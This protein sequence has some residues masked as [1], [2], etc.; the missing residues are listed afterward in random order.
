MPPEDRVTKQ[1]SIL[2]SLGE[3]RAYEIVYRSTYGRIRLHAEVT[4]DSSDGQDQSAPAWLHNVMQCNISRHL[5]ILVFREYQR[6]AWFIQ[7]VSRLA[8]VLSLSILEHALRTRTRKIACPGQ[9]EI[10]TR[11]QSRNTMLL[12]SLGR[13]GLQRH[14]CA[15]HCSRTV[16]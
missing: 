6:N 10:L 2:T 15:E 16:S 4:S 13:H 11:L 9:E 3:L 12:A 8:P 7:G 1:G 5:P 14:K